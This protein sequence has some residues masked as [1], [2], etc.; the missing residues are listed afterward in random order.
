MNSIKSGG[1]WIFF[2]YKACSFS[3]FLLEMFLI[4]LRIVLSVWF[5]EFKCSMDAY[6]VAQ[7]SL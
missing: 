3:T 6:R 5:Y 2:Y 7:E 1:K 4:R